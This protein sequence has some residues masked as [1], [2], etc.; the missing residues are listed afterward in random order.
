LVQIQFQAIFFLEASALFF[1]SIKY[2][3]A[4]IKEKFFE[5][6]FY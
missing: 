5:L 2:I 6:F 1:F 3:N 4:Y